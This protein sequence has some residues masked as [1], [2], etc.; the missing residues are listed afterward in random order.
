VLFF[1]FFEIRPLA[2]AA[3]PTTIDNKVAKAR[4]STKL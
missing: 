2:C 4:V 3:P 1:S